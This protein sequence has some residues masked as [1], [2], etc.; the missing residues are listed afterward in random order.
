MYSIGSRR[1][2]TLRYDDVS[3][4]TRHG[5]TMEADRTPRRGV[6]ARSPRSTG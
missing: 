4:L 1:Q 5:G 3:A 2:G 6:S